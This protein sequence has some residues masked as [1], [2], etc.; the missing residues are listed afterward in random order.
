MHIEPALFAFGETA[1]GNGNGDQHGIAS[2]HAAA[3]LI[4]N[5]KSLTPNVSQSSQTP[6]PN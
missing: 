6:T 3:T 1:Y 2:L 5:I 4:M